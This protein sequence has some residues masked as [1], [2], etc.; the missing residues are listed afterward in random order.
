VVIVDDDA[1][2]DVIATCAA[3]S[4]RCSVI[5]SS[6]DLDLERAGGLTFPTGSRSGSWLSMRTVPDPADKVHRIRRIPEKKPRISATD[7]RREGGTAPEER[8]AMQGSG[9][10]YSD[11]RATSMGNYA[12]ERR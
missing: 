1:C 3:K 10:R 8:P 2:F 4:P 12:A 6:L 9:D 11:K 5:R 7:L